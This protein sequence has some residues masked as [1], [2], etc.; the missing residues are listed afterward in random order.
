[1]HV[2]D[3]QLTL[4]QCINPP[5]NKQH[6]TIWQ[7]TAAILLP[8]YRSPCQLLAL[9]TYNGC[10]PALVK[11]F[12]VSTLTRLSTEPL[13]FTCQK[14]HTICVKVLNMVFSC[15]YNTNY[16]HYHPWPDSIRLP[17]PPNPPGPRQYVKLVMVHTSQLYQSKQPSD[18][19]EFYNTFPLPH[20]YVSSLLLNNYKLGF[21]WL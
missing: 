11:Q 15:P 2:T 12:S 6:A 20:T 4:C 3:R 13:I 9:I 17:R 16:R 7:D 5:T 1:M 10:S 14:A 21:A 19:W 8:H 18:K